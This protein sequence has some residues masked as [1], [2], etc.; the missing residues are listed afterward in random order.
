MKTNGRRIRIFLTLLLISYLYL[1]NAYAELDARGSGVIDLRGFITPLTP[2]SQAGFSISSGEYIRY[3]TEPGDTNGTIRMYKNNNWE[4]FVITEG[5]IDRR[6]DTSW[7]PRPGPDPDVYC[8]NSNRAIY[9]LSRDLPPGDGNHV[10]GSAG[11]VPQKV[12]FTNFVARQSSQLMSLIP[13]DAVE[14]FRSGG[15]VRKQC[16]LRDTSIGVYPALNQKQDLLLTYYPKGKYTFCSGLKN[17]EDLIEIKVEN[18]FGQGDV[19]LFMKGWGFVG[20][21]D[22]TGRNAGLG[23]GGNCAQGGGSPNT[24]VPPSGADDKG[25]VCSSDPSHSNFSKLTIKG[26]LKSNR[27]HTYDPLNPKKLIRVADQ[28]SKNPEPRY[29]PIITN[30]K[31]VGGIVAV[32]KSQKMPSPPDLP[33]NME[34]VNH[35]GKKDGKIMGKLTE[36]KTTTSG[37]FQIETSITCDEVWDGSKGGWKQ[38][39]A[40]LCPDNPDGNGG[41]L[42]LKDLYAIHL[43]PGNK[44]AVLDLRDINVDCDA[45]AYEHIKSTNYFA[46]NDLNY[47]FRNKETFLACSATE[48]LDTA[49]PKVNISYR[50]GDHG[51]QFRDEKSIPYIHGLPITDNIINI[52]KEIIL[53]IIFGLLNR[54]EAPFK[55]RTEGRISLQRVMCD[56]RKIYGTPSVFFRGGK[57][58]FLHIPNF[59]LKTAP[60]GVETFNNHEEKPQLFDCE[61]L[62]RSSRYIGE[63]G[64]EDYNAQTA[65][66]FYNNLAPPF[67]GIVRKP[68]GKIDPYLSGDAARY[69]AAN[70]SRNPL[71][72][73][74][75]CKD[76]NNKE[77]YLG[78]FMPPEGFCGDLDNSNDINGGE[79]PCP[80]RFDCG[81]YNGDGE[82]KP[83]DGEIDCSQVKVQN[84]NLQGYG[85]PGFYKFDVRYFPYFALDIGF[86]RPL[87]KEENYRVFETNDDKY[88]VCGRKQPF[89]AEEDATGTSRPDTSPECHGSG[90]TSRAFMGQVSV[91]KPSVINGVSFF[92]SLNILSPELTGKF[93]LSGVLAPP[94]FIDSQDSLTV[95]RETSRRMGEIVGVQDVA[96]VSRIGSLDNLCTCSLVEGYWDTPPD[97]GNCFGDAQAIGGQPPNPKEPLNS[98]DATKDYKLAGEGGNYGV[99]DVGST[100]SKVAADYDWSENLIKSLFLKEKGETTAPTT[101]NAETHYQ[102]PVD[103]NVIEKVIG[104]AKSLKE[105]I[106]CANP[107]VSQ[108]DNK[109]T[110]TLCSRRI[111]VI[112]RASIWTPG[113]TLTTFSKNWFVVGEALT[114]PFTMIPDIDAVCEFDTS[115]TKSYLFDESLGDSP[116]SK[117]K[118]IY[119]AES[120][121]NSFSYLTNSVKPPS[122]EGEYEPSCVKVKVDGWHVKQVS[123]SGPNHRFL[124]ANC[125]KDGGSC[126]VGGIGYEGGYSL[127]MKSGDGGINWSV[128]FSQGGGFV[129]GIGVDKTSGEVVAAGRYGRIY[130]RTSDSWS[131]G[132]DSL[133]KF[134]RDIPYGQYLYD[135]AKS[136][137]GYIATGTG[138][139]FYSPNGGIWRAIAK[140]NIPAPPAECLNGN[141]AACE[142]YSVG[143]SDRDYPL[144]CID[145]EYLSSPPING[146]NCDENPNT[147]KPSCSL[148]V[149][150]GGPGQPRCCGGEGQPK[151]CCVGNKNDPDPDLDPSTPYCPDGTK[152]SSSWCWTWKDTSIW[153]V[154]CN[155]NGDCIIAG[156]SSPRIWWSTADK[157]Y[158]NMDS[159][160]LFSVATRLGV[161][162]N[163]MDVSYPD[164][165]VAY[166]VGGSSSDING[167]AG[168]ILKTNDKGKNWSAII[169]PGSGTPDLSGISCY[170]ANNCVAVGNNATVL[171]TKDGGNKWTDWAD[172]EE[173]KNDETLKEAKNLGVRFVD[174]AY[175]KDKT[176]IIVGFIPGQG[177]AVI[178]SLGEKEVCQESAPQPPSGGFV[179]CP[180]DPSCN[181][182]SCGSCRCWS[183]NVSANRGGFTFCNPGEGTWG[184][185]WIK[186]NNSSKVNQINVPERSC[187]SVPDPGCGDWSWNSRASGCQRQGGGGGHVPC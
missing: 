174:V 120:F 166:V 32:Y 7:A 44:D 60:Q 19:F 148:P 165:N 135:V 65:G 34:M 183:A 68:D 141:P 92:T 90:S 130:R 182:A 57:E 38:Y 73:L 58:A 116:Y 56:M 100:P 39:L 82:I 187:V 40:I 8:A 16:S 128:E 102:Q 146:V 170:D 46:P 155:E 5:W 89:R 71:T 112:G 96:G 177:K 99:F 52:V 113:K 94:Q 69:L 10:P 123:A 176:I 103:P 134:E 24:M 184:D 59:Y 29:Y 11:W 154:D 67:G 131:S 101:N 118:E 62:R 6:E 168:F 18:G 169:K 47:V 173:W 125:T 77:Y 164:A 172:I 144:N 98:F 122:F 9:T 137:K 31:V 84:D 114:A 156:Q 53:D 139:V 48:G 80:E 105:I 136:P 87:G 72:A 163:N 22:P 160:Q 93:P 140:P 76:K 70:K 119:E 143:C 64:Y 14:T 108:E 157:D 66:G 127:I 27:L 121:E 145:K 36:Q 178:Y 81:D 109:Q 28:S 106:E 129:H 150:C 17:E 132:L 4:Q 126:W 42:M 78:E 115:Y 25:P 161:F 20:F 104:V 159:W 49:L 181:A 179:Q 117:G 124:A 133:V 23:S 180:G 153:G 55:G 33:P 79:M 26:V 110:S 37:T 147:P 45:N 152:Q 175:P 41:R 91:R 2:K 12:R 88:P 63:E 171:I 74:A 142:G 186:W 107:S 86:T 21:R 75:V 162:G 30:Q 61:M 97:L 185:I 54:G 1:N 138:Y 35:T 158:S 167:N 13:I 95:V 43:R 85:R 50:A 151:C 111:N 15:R 149:G 51:L 83:E 3:T